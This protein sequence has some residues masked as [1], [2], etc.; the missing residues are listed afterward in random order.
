MTILRHVT[1]VRNVQ[2]IL[3]QGLIP[4]GGSEEIFRKHDKG[5]VSFEKDPP[6][7]W[8][9]ENIHIVKPNDFQG[10]A[11]ALDFDEDCIRRTRPC[12]DVYDAPRGPVELLLEKETKFRDEDDLFRHVGGYVKVRGVVSLSCLTPESRARIEALAN[13]GQND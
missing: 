6:S 7:N 2:S 5:W 12:E 3:T 9:V 13:F 11:I 1:S 4:E 8:L 10:P